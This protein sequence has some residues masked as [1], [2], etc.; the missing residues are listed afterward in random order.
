MTDVLMPR[1]SDSMQEGTILTWLAADGDDIVE[2]QEL[3]EV[4]TDKATMTQLS[5]ASGVLSIVVAE[6]TTIAVGE[7]IA[8]LEPTEARAGAA[9][10]STAPEATTEP[11][12]APTSEL[13]ATASAVAAAA[14]VADGSPPATVVANGSGPSG[15]GSAAEVPATPMA[16]RI[17]DAH[18]IDLT[19]LA[20]SGPRGRVVRA[21]VI[22]AAGLPAEPPAAAAPAR[23]PAPVPAAR[24]AADAPMAVADATAAGAAAAGAPAAGAA[25]AGGRGATER[26][27]LSRLQQLIARRMAEAKATIPEFQVQTEVEMTAAVG[28]R[29]QLKQLAESQSVPAP[30]L[31]DL[32]VKACALCLRRHPRANG[33]YADGAFELHERVNVGV[34][35]AA[36]DALVVPVIHDA[37]VKMLGQIAAIGR[38]LAESVRAG[39]ITPPELSGATFTVSNLGMYGMTAITPVINPPQAAILG[40]GAIRDVLGR[41]ADGEIVD[42]KLLSLTLSCDHRILY[43]ADAATFLAAI[44]Q[45]LESP[46]GLAL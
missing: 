41:D 8:R 13:G 6:G 1:L 5:E 10:A 36:D 34:A 35:V 26:V 37:D 9:A 38:R 25:A 12:A 45:L 44:K 28:F 19:S 27:A 30:S 20:G 2:G 22:A 29:A 3:V 21:D 42:R 40:V 43:G 39:T 16:R 7:V 15:N 33:S 14:P 17:A 46:L 11:G 23:D 24:A 32:I 18:G 31:N 4:E